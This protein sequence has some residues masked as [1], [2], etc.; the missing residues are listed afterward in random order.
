MLYRGRTILCQDGQALLHQ[1]RSIEDNQ[2]KTQREDI[3][4]GA[5][6]EKVADPLL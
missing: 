1:E 4:A 6:F 3:V 5:N 2:A